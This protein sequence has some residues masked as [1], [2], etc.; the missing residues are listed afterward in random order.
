[1]MIW[2]I[3]L[4]LVAVLIGIPLSVALTGTTVALGAVGGSWRYWVCAP[5]ALLGSPPSWW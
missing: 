4:L 2:G 1:M 3:V 5:E